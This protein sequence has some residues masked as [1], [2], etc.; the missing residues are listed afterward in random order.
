MRDFTEVAERLLS[1]LRVCDPTEDL[2]IVCEVLSDLWTTAGEGNDPLEDALPPVFPTPQYTYALA[3]HGET[4][5]RAPICYDDGESAPLE[6]ALLPAGGSGEAIL[7]Y[8]NTCNQA[9]AV[10]DLLEETVF[11]CPK[12]GDTPGWWDRT[13]EKVLTTEDLR[14]MRT[15]GVV[16]S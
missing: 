6:D 10:S 11:A 13:G 8:C 3:Q 16:A 1:M 15:G 7:V 9:P 2:R 5:E 4:R 12:C 14:A